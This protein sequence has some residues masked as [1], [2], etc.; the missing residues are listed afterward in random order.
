MT[1]TLQIN[2]FPDFIVAPVYTQIPPRL[3]LAKGGA[4]N[5]LFTRWGERVGFQSLSLN[6]FE[7]CNLKFEIFL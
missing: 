4:R 6:L 1:N 5:F 7:I 3:P 2:L